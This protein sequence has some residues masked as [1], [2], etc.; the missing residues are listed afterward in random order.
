MAK[1]EFSFTSEFQQQMLALMLK[2]FS[3][4]A[5]V[6]NYIPVD[7]LYSEA[8]KYI[9]EQI[10]VSLDKKELLTLI[11]LEDR[12]KTMD[13]SKRRL[14][15]SFASELFTTKVE[16]PD[17][18][19]TKLTEYAKKCSFIDV[20]TTSQT[21]WNAKQHDKAYEYA[22]MGMNELYTVNFEDDA[23]IPVEKFEEFRQLFVAD[24]MKKSIQIPTA[25]PSLDRAL[26]GGLTKGELG[27]LLAEPKKGKSIGLIHMGASALMAGFGRVAHFVLEGTTDQCILRYLSRMSGIEYA[28]LEKDTITPEEQKK[29]DRLMKKFINRLDLIPMNKHWNYT[30]FDI[31]AK[32]KELK[33]VGRNPDVI[34]IDYADLLSSGVA[35]ME[36]RLDQTEVYRNVKKL[37]VMGNYAIWTASQAQRPSKEPDEVYLLRAKDISESYEKVRI[38]DLVAT[39]NQT[40]RERENGLLR[41]HL[42]IYRSN[43]AD[44][45]M[46]LIT[47]YEKMIFYSPLYGEQSS[48]NDL[49]DWMLKKKRSR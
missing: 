12:L 40:T 45:T 16:N 41:F 13:R 46:T 27:I 43:D 44:E 18:I 3:F 31:E 37:A 47:N 2:D 36:K 17:F 25:I 11:E 15:K 28:R 39:L 6:I 35:G 8:H 42:D 22:M 4:A 9:F 33:S 20:F 32:L 23:V 30:V 19:K 21:F 10:K 29:I 5:R 1:I 48:K 34:I 7:R 14:M 38:A 26:R 49:F 24:S